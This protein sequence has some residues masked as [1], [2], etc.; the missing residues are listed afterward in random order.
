MVAY[1]YGPVVEKVYRTFKEY[2]A[3]AIKTYGSTEYILKDIYFSQA[4]G[5]ILL[6]KAVVKNVLILLKIVVIYSEFSRGELV[7]FTH[8]EKNHRNTVY[9]PYSNCKIND[10][11]TFT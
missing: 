1:K 4:I 2:E 11:I 5:R 6:A 3:S 10:D 7:N 9:L 8:S